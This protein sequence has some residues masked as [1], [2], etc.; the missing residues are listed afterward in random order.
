MK[1]REPDVSK[2][3][4]HVKYKFWKPW[5]HGKVL[6]LLK[7]LW[8]YEKAISRV[9][10]DKNPLSSHVKKIKGNEIIF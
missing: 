2:W 5:I 8:N 9:K 6:G 4:I 1:S 7:N 10:Q 3:R